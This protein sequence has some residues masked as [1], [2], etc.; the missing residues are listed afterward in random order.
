MKDPDTRLEALVSLDWRLETGSC[1][2]ELLRPESLK[3]RD[4]VVISTEFSLNLSSL[5]CPLP[6][7]LFPDSSK[8]SGGPAG[9]PRR[10][11]PG[12]SSNIKYFCRE[13]GRIYY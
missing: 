10:V 12:K 8:I 9:T 11:K 13:S 3:E 7:Q 4:F 2:A 1:W 5:P 6:F